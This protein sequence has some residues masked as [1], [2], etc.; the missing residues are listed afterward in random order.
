MWQCQQTM[1]NKLV[2]TYNKISQYKNL[3]IDIEKNVAP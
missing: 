1:M 3:E 2:K